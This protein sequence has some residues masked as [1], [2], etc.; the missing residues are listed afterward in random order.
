MRK[1]GISIEVIQAIRSVIDSLNAD[2]T[3]ILKGYLTEE[4]EKFRVGVPTVKIILTR[5]Y[6]F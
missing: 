5:N 2:V 4:V 3:N 6:H 1:K